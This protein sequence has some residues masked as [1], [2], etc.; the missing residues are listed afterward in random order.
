MSGQKK[1]AVA[2]LTLGGAL[3]A[4]GARV[5]SVRGTAEAMASAAALA[6]RQTKAGLDAE[7]QRLETQALAAAQTKPLLAALEN[8]VD[9]NTLVDLFASE[10][11]WREMRATFSMA[12]VVAGS[13]VL[14]T[15]GAPDPGSKDREVV[16]A[17]RKNRS[18]STV[19]LIG[20]QPTFV[21]ASRLSTM[22]DK[23]PVLVL[24][25]GVDRALWGVTTP[26]APVPG[27]SPLDLGVF[28]LALL[29]GLGGGVMFIFSRSRPVT[30]TSVP[31]TT[32]RENTLRF[33]S[34]AQKQAAP[35][36]GT[37]ARGPAVRV[38]D[39]KNDGR[40]DAAAFA[41]IPRAVGA[42]PAPVGPPRHPTAP[43]GVPSTE[44][45]TP[46]QKFGRYALL[47][48]LGQG[49]MADVFTAVAHGVEG[50]SRVFV[51]K[52]LRP[53]LS[54]DKEAVAQFIDEARMQSNLV[55]SNIVPVFDFGRVANEYFMTQ[56]YIVGRDLV[57]LIARYYEHCQQTIPARLAYYIAHETLQALQY[58]HTKQDREGKHLEIVHRDVS[59]GN[60]IV[61]A[62]GEVKL[63]DFGIV[64]SNT[65]TSKTQM[66]M[67]KGNA[68]FMSPEQARGQSVDAR[69]DLFSVALVLYYCL[70]NRLFYDGTND[71][72]VL[73]KAASGP[74]MDDYETIRQ[75]GSP[76]SD[77]LGRALAPDPAQRFQSAAEFADVLAPH[78]GGAKAEAARLMHT[79]FGEELRKEAA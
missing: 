18:A 46:G 71:L 7:R 58:A 3:G 62:E 9:G 40:N 77:V 24:A 41:P 5:E 33:G 72:D 37:G 30:A 23:A 70:T 13:E 68:N 22:P 59:A 31:R 53:E 11:W 8:S 74:T 45:G 36:I 1:V 20:G 6:A 76:A 38:A 35:D 51:L 50:F 27:R 79:L 14:G 28:A 17:A 48:R 52:R 43:G 67:V 66:G 78:I 32:A 75:L 4:Y 39:A 49:G 65:R 44:N 15:Y 19:L 26:P 29:L 57:R 61:S 63:A 56:E 47:D 2:L 73:F 21:V 25:K 34:T 69:S 10:D 55:H 64:K 60:I 54:Q 12:R 42:T 16:I